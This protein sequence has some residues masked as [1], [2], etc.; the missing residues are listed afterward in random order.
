VDK[1]VLA[2]AVGGNEAEAFCVL[3]HFT[4]P[5]A[6]VR[7]PLRVLPAACGSLAS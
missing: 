6:I 1:D 4:V 2:A 5:V 3:N 7:S